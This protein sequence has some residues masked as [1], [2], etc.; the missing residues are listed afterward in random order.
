[1]TIQ[2]TLLYIYIHTFI[3]FSEMCVEKF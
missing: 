1:M 2:Q 3:S